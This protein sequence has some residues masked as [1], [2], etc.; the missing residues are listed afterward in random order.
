MEPEQTIS[1]SWLGRP[2]FS[3]L[4]KLNIETLLVTIILILA[5]LSRFVNLG[6]RVISH[7]EVNVVV[8]AYS[9]YTGN[10]YAYDPV[11]HGPLEFHMMALSYFLL[12]D[13]DF[14]SRAPDAM[15]SVLTI[16]FVLLAF[17]RYLG[18]TGALTV[19]YT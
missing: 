1:I 12:G 18:R 10:G 8:P 19:S 11:T 6:A 7:D 4:P 2:V 14:A 3:F 13:S 16:L 5:V 9:L 17:R 15:V